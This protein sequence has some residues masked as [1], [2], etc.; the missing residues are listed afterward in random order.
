MDRWLAPGEELKFF[1]APLN[2]QSSWSNGERTRVQFAEQTQVSLS[3]TLSLSSAWI[4][5]LRSVA[6]KQPEILQ[7]IMLRATLQFRFSILFDS[8]FNF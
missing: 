5:W 6:G 8:L 1:P 4:G 2:N 3:L 7:A